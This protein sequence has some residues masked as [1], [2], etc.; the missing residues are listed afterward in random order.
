LALRDG[1]TIPLVRVEGGSSTMRTTLDPPLAAAQPL[2]RIPL[3]GPLVQSIYT[4]L[5]ENSPPICV[6]GQLSIGM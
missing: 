4:A 5:E 6:A 1:G 3:V 2:L